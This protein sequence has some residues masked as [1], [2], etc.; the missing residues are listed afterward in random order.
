MEDIYKAG[1]GDLAST[2]LK[3][4]GRSQLVLDLALTVPVLI[5]ALGLYGI[6][7]SL[8]LYLSGIS[9]FNFQFLLFLNCII[10]SSWF[11]FRSWRL[12]LSQW[13]IQLFQKE[14]QT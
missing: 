7:I 5:K 2:P 11:R 3:H 8:F 10:T 13:K 6:L 4:K 9:N 14:L 1:A 12:N